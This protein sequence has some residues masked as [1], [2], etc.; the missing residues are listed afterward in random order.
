MEGSKE[1]YLKLTD[2]LMVFLDLKEQDLI[3]LVDNDD[4][5]WTIEKI[6]LDNNGD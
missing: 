1:V 4:G 5:T 2:E 3:N 6:M